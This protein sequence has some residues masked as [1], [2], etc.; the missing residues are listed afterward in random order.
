LLLFGSDDQSF[1]ALDSSRGVSAWKWRNKGKLRNPAVV[2]DGVV[3]FC[4]D[5]TLYA[6]DLN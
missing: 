4:G 1:H 2:G 6:I 5:D 3:Y